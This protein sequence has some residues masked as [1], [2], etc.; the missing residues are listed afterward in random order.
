MLELAAAA[1]GYESIGI[2]EYKPGD[3]AVEAYSSEL[4]AYGR[5]AIA[6]TLLRQPVPAAVPPAP[7][8]EIPEDVRLAFAELKRKQKN[9]SDFRS[10]RESLAVDQPPA[11]TPASD[12]EREKR[13]QAEQIAEAL[14][15]LYWWGRLSLEH[16]YNSDTVIGVRDWIRGGM[17][18]DLPPLPTW[19]ADRCPPL[20]S[21]AIPQSPHGEEVG[22]DD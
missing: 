4:I 21:S 5:A 11:P 7:A 2:D 12:G 20:T 18:G 22:N 9:L 1:V 13:P 8:P 3:C 6:A 14:A 15:R 19:I 10:L 16:G 17:L